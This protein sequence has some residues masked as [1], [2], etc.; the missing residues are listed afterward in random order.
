[1]FAL[2]FNISCRG[3]GGWGH[4]IIHKLK[5]FGDKV[6][7]ILNCKVNQN[8]NVSLFNNM[9]LDNLTFPKSSRRV[10]GFCF[11]FKRSIELRKKVIS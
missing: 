11:F 7:L 9:E 6:Y 4:L 3:G 10:G 8:L 2:S 5:G 1:M